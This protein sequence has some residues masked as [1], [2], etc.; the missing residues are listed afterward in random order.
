M[1][2]GSSMQPPSAQR[3]PHLPLLHAASLVGAVST[4]LVGGGYGRPRSR[5]GPPQGLLLAFTTR[6]TPCSSMLER[7]L[8]V[9]TG[10]IHYTTPHT[11]TTTATGLPAALQPG[12]PCEECGGR[13]AAEGEEARHS[14][15]C[16]TVC[17]YG[18]V[19]GVSSVRAQWM[20]GRRR[21]ERAT[22]GWCV[23]MCVCVCVRAHA[24]ACV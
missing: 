7:A 3:P 1:D 15:W 18:E 22:D 2:L 20:R 24:R 10:P 19:G 6:T 23:C 9:H 14:E 16:T 13:G 11:P 17:V 4:P 8:G 21:G 12:A 5:I